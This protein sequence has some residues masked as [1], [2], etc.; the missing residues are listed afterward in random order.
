MK[1]IHQMLSVLLLNI[2]I[3]CSSPETYDI[4]IKNGQ[5]TD[6]SGQP[7]Y[8]GDLGINADTIAAIGKLEHAK[9][10]QE[11]DASGLVVAPG[12][13]NMLSWATESLIVDGKSQSDIR[14]G[15]TL[16]VMG[17]GWS[18]GPL[19]EKM[20]EEQ[21]RTQKDIKYDIEW[22]TL[23][24]YLEF[25]ERKGVSTNV[26]SFV[27]ATTLRVHEL[28]EAN[29]APTPEELKNMKA[30]AKTAMEEGAMGIG[31]SLIYAPAF[32]ADTQELIELCKVA[33]A[34][35]GMYISH[36]RSEGDYWL[37]AIDELLQIA[38]EANIPAEIYHLK[39]GGKDNWSKWE[40]AIAKI[41]S[42]R[43]A[44]L[45]I[46]T[47]MYNYTAGATGLD[48]SMPPWVQE[49]GYGKWAERLQDPAI[50]EKV[51]EEM[52]AKGDGW[53]NL[54]F[55][56]GSADKL[57]L[58]DFRS[59]SLRYLTGKTLAEVATMR[60]TSPEETA[61]DLVVQDSSRVGTVYFLMSEENVK[62]QIALP[63]MSFGSDGASIA[64][65][66]PFTNASPHPRSYGNVARLLG[67]Y[68]REEKVIS[69]EEA[70]YKL[71]GLP[72]SNLKIKNRGTLAIGNFADVA[73]F[74]SETIIDKATFD[75]PHQFAEGM[76]H[77]LVNGE[78]VLKDGEHTGALPGKVVRG[79]GWKQNN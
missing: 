44:G 55:A 51:I 43:T 37:E 41:D 17:E 24:E 7:M 36:M 32:Y 13:I 27:G 64:P 11:I 3:G 60:G 14:Q 26:A 48:A 38:N 76:V 18:M 49:G 67:K 12:F 45:K 34:H 52:K 54:Y 53:E 33:S 31:S 22:T 40:A 20:R 28:G 25:L 66:K 30:L 58:N 29:R 15:V 78:Q 57:I 47:D 75:K 42:A 61:I 59:D 10:V 46:T 19:N 9:G 74:N 6:G 79:P 56:A 77:V 72:A 8:L 68:V 21:Q 62:K 73:I 63:Y 23:G 1:P 69:L 39:A 65:V 70:V 5:I 4:L 2:L 35:N 50:R 16:E 71:S